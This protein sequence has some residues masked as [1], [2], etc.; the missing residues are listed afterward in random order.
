MPA[1]TAGVPEL[2]R[3]IGV[4]P[5]GLRGRARGEAPGTRVPP[6]HG[7]KK[8]SEGPSPQGCVEFDGPAVTSVARWRSSGARGR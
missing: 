1:G 6:G 3:S 2:G 7:W 8:R 4:C 5:G